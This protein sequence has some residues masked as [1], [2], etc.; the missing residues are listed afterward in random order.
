MKSSH[1]LNHEQPCTRSMFADKIESEEEQA[2][3]ARRRSRFSSNLFSLLS[4]PFYSNQPSIH[5][6]SN[7]YCQCTTFCGIWLELW[8]WIELELELEIV[9]PLS[10]SDWWLQ[11]CKFVGLVRFFFRSLFGYHFMSFCSC[12][13]TISIGAVVL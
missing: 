13:E 10:P 2:S 12:L 8:L 9:G 5:P 7:D 3:D 1:E 11:L 6:P 4:F